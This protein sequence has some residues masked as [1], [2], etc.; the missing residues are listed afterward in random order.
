M[1]PASP[2]TNDLE[3][4]VTGDAILLNSDL[5]G[6]KRKE[7]K[8]KEKGRREGGGGGKKKKESVNILYLSGG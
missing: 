6:K 1:V 5:R 3:S 4:E 8:K 2:S 7:K